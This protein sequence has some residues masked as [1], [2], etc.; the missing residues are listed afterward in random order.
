MGL[1][2]SLTKL[3]FCASVFTQYIQMLYKPHCFLVLQFGNYYHAVQCM[4][5]WINNPFLMKLW[6]KES[7]LNEIVWNPESHSRVSVQVK[8]RVCCYWP[9]VTCTWSR[10]VMVS[11]H[12]EQR[13]K[14]GDHQWLVG[15]SLLVEEIFFRN[16]SLTNPSHLIATLC[17]L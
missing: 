12:R 3:L 16:L 7:K 13:S 14:S 6:P 1:I 9:A 10:S 5:F 4:H 8:R 15:L 11:T 17:S 2:G